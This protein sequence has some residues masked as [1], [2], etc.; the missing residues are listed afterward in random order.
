M[1]LYI[2]NGMAVHYAESIEKVP[3]NLREV[4]PTIFV[5]VPRIFEKVYA[6]AKLKAAPTGGLKE[7]IFDWAIVKQK[8]MPWRRRTGRPSLRR[9]R[10][11][12]NWPTGLSFQS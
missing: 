8:S 7:K 9:L 1:Y 2:L 10:S 5:G 4:R 6:K 11:S 3:D 12:M